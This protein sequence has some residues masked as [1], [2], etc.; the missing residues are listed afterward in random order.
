[1]VF[2]LT[3]SAAFA[4]DEDYLMSLFTVPG[5]AQ[6][7][8]AELANRHPF[9][10][11]HALATW[12]KKRCGLNDPSPALF[13]AAGGEAGMKTPEGEKTFLVAGVIASM[14]FKTAAESDNF[15]D[16]TRRVIAEAEN[17]AK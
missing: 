16:T 3:A 6:M 4:L 2:L 1:M 11:A 15:C 17:L 14:K 8:F 7:E 12:S 10:A 9:V 5:K 13:A